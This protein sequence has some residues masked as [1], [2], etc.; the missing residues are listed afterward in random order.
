MNKARAQGRTI[1]LV[2]LVHSRTARPSPRTR[3]NSASR[4]TRSSLYFETQYFQTTRNL[5]PNGDSDPLPNNNM[6]TGARFDISAAYDFSNRFEIYG[7]GNFNQEQAVV[8]NGPGL[9]GA[10]KTNGEPGDLK[11]GMNYLLLQKFVSIDP[12]CFGE[13]ALVP[14]SRVP[15][16]IP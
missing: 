7:E 15:T 9:G 10:I 6:V 13:R 11:L 14:D 16:P 3:I 4:K 5:D 12:R 8:N 1:L 2:S